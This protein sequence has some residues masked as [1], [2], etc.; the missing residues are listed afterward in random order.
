MP[1]TS[2]AQ[3]ERHRSPDAAPLDGTC[4][5]GSLDVLSPDCPSRIV[6]GRIGERWSMFVILA[7]AGRTLRFTQLRAKVGVVTP[8]VLTETLRALE[9]DGIVDRRA[10]AESPP[11]VE[12]SL[13]PLGTSLL[14]PI[15]AMRVWAEAHVPEV[16]ASRERHLAEADAAVLG[17][18]P[19]GR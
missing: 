16:L 18:A 1:N 13:T 8:K 6:F 19:A 4:E 15:Q 10:Y 14:E 5:V 7:L 17:G 3:I 2:T 9:A 11:R 12:Y